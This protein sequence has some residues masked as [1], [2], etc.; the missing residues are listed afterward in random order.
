MTGIKSINSL[1]FCLLCI[2]V[3]SPLAIT[4]V[5][6]TDEHDVGIANVVADFA[7]TWR[8]APSKINVTLTN[9]G[10]WDEMCNLTVYANSTVNHPSFPDIYVIGAAN[11]INL[12]A[13]NSTTITVLWDGYSSELG[14]TVPFGAYTIIASVTPV[15]GETNIANNTLVSRTILVS[16]YPDVNGDGKVNVID[17]IIIVIKLG[18][19]PPWPPWWARIDVK[20]DG[21]INILDLIAVASHLGYIFY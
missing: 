7:V 5:R 4:R 8:G 3:V 19:L 6:A 16:E 15:A 14:D 1:A 17:L 20:S 9:Y 13:G 12:T 11:E 21:A 18:K 10:V 2:I